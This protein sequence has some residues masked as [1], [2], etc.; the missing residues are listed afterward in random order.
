MLFLFIFM[1]QSAASSHL[2]T[3]HDTATFQLLCIFLKSK[4]G[5][6]MMR[7]HLHTNSYTDFSWDT[8]STIPKQ[9]PPGA[10]RR[11]PSPRF[12]MRVT[13]IAAPRS[14]ALVLAT[15]PLATRATSTDRQKFETDRNSKRP[16]KKKV[17]MIIHDFQCVFTYIDQ[18]YL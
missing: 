14:Q 16:P 5:I 6:T 2:A 12:R 15:L 3:L 10:V 13:E 4:L 7:F 17:S 8:F 9:E 18:T 11:V 1:A